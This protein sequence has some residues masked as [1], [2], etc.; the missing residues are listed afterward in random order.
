MRPVRRVRY[1]HGGHTRA[2]DSG[3]LRGGVL[4]SVPLAGTG[5]RFPRGCAKRHL[6]DRRAPLRDGDRSARVQ[7][8]QLGEIASDISN[9]V[10]VAP[11]R[12]RKTL[13]RALEAIILRAL[14]KSPA[15]RYQRASD[16][17]DDL[18]R[19][20]RAIDGPIGILWRGARR[21]RAGIVT[22]AGLVLLAMMGTAGWWWKR[23]T[24]VERSAILVSD[25]ANGTADPDFE[26][27]L[28]EAVSV[29]LAQSPYLDLVSDERIRT[30]LQLMGRKP[31]ARMTHEVAA[32]LCQ[33][34]GLQAMLEGS[35]SAVGR[36][37]VVAL[38]ATDCSTGATIAKEVTEVERKEDVLKAMG[39]LTSSIRRSLGES[40]AS[41]ARNNTP[42]E[43]A[44]TPSLEAL[45]AY[46][47]A[48]QRRA[49]GA[50]VAA[51]ELLERAIAIDPQ[52]ALAHTTLSSI[53]GGFGETGRS[54]EYARL[55]YEHRDRV[56]ERERLF[57]TYQYHD[58]VTGDQLKTREA[59]EVWKRTY[60]KDYR[61]SNALALLLIRLGD[62]AA[63]IVEAEDA[64]QRNPVHAFPRSN[65]AHAL[66][67]AG[68][69]AERAP[70]RREG[71]GGEARDRPDAPTALSA[72][73]TARRP[74]AGAAADRLGGQS[75]AQL[76]HQ[77]R[78]RTGRA[79]SRP[80]GRGA[81]AVRG[82][83]DR[84]D[85]ARVSAGRVRLRGAGGVRRSDLRL[86]PRAA[87]AGPRCRSVG[88]RLRAAAASGDRAGAWRRARGGGGARPPFARRPAAG[89]VAP[90]RVPAGRR[91][92]RAAGAGKP[93]DAI[94][95]LRRATPYENGIVAALLPVY[96]R[97]EARLRAGAPAEAAR[98]FQSILAHRGADPFSPVVAMAQ[99][100]LA[101]AYARSG[102]IAESRAAYETV[103]ATWA[104][105]D[106]D[107]PVLLQ[108]RSELGGVR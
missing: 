49:A 80:R 64:M 57:I 67:G 25:I 53:Y 14:D 88:D 54:E 105:A 19:V 7:G 68:R 33:R 97:G 63:A 87:G 89:H 50:E 70:G 4:P 27:T 90:E 51:V 61:P 52:F 79:V 62:Y 11:R 73:R 92:G 8:Q 71:A 26:G 35:V 20:R 86:R 55:A 17:V 85:R 106:P 28:R 29:Y 22:A 91:S 101:R 98:E 82:D 23:S 60:P 34:L 45:K 1:P 65:L 24:P 9:A 12:I 31:E 42:I 69:Y 13:P 77:R 58:R 99:L 72:R 74:G 32:E 2:G 46:T 15:D 107:L 43:E 108:A 39:Q 83:D 21:G 18:R 5:R 84:R 94:A 104:G 103:F 102:A 3:R 37:T 36:T 96:V 38:A 41:L 59:L 40:G 76:R 95:E 6:R 44:T 30:T 75:S 16:L 66:R 56:S 100:G 48:V 81:P 10:P 78:A 93:D 47:E